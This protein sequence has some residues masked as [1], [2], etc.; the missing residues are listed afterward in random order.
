METQGIKHDTCA[1]QSSSARQETPPRLT[2]APY[3]SGADSTLEGG[4]HRNQASGPHVLGSAARP[5][6]L[7]ARETVHTSH[8][9]SKGCHMQHEYIAVPSMNTPAQHVLGTLAVTPVLE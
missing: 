2:L 7:R 5:Q 8:L 4:I 1:E 6:T 9:H 3:P